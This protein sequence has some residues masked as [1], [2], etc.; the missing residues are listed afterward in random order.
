MNFPSPVYP[1]LISRRL[2]LDYCLIQA[3]SFIWDRKLESLLIDLTGDDGL[4][5]D[6]RLLMRHG[7]SSDGSHRFILVYRVVAA[8]STDIGRDGDAK[9][10]DRQGRPILHVE[11]M[12]VDGT[13]TFEK[14]SLSSHWFTKEVHLP[15]MRNFKLFWQ[16]EGG[17][18]ISEP[19]ANLVN[20][21]DLDESD[22]LIVFSKQSAPQY[23]LS[24]ESHG[25][26]SK[27]PAPHETEAN[28]NRS[29]WSK[30]RYPF[31]VVS[32]FLALAAILRIPSSF[33]LSRCD[34]DRENLYKHDL[35]SCDFKGENLSAK[36]LSGANLHASNL[37]GADLRKAKLT[38]ADLTNANLTKADLRGAD[39]RFAKLNGAELKSI[40]S[41]DSTIWPRWSMEAVKSRPPAFKR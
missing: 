16:D 18:F 24:N 27:T 8:I 22:A 6:N 7:F 26:K 20:D 17:N 13:D 40:V 19:I 12:I 28:Q 32:C 23:V 30:Y 1:F 10:R 3:P 29:F 25:E 11:G 31:I 5:P 36:N 15:L 39:L 14:Q 37:A 35:S 21:L 34:L 38:S 41:D 9:L 4:S 33:K 2:D